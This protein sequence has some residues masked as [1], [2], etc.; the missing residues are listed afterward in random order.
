DGRLDMGHARALLGAPQAMQADLAQQVA[1][2]GLTVRQAEALVQAALGGERPR[3][4]RPT[5]SPRLARFEHDLA[6]A[7]GT[8][9]A[10]RPGRGGRGS[11]V[12]DYASVDDLDSLVDRLK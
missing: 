7:L 10:I 9:V 12:I 3:K 2:R 5:Q 11:V 8:R 1:K 6:S 4:E